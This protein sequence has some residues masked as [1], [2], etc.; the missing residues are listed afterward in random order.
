M[1]AYANF[2]C[3]KLIKFLNNQAIIKKLHAVTF[4]SV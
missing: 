2:Q 4:E 3:A 1:K